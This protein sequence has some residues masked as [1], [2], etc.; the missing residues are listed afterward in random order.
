MSLTLA[1]LRERLRQLIQDPSG[2]IW[3]DA[4]LDEAVRLA[5][6]EYNLAKSPAVLSGLDG[7]ETTTLPEIYESALLLGAAGYAACSRALQRS[8]A[9]LPGQE[10]LNSLMDWGQ[11][12]LGEFRA[13]LGSSRAAEESR[14]TGLHG[15]VQPPF[16]AGTGQT[17]GGWRWEDEQ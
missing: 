4:G 8:A 17:S 3:T 6:H 5:L 16:P 1:S 12:R 2:L 10:G 11:A 13:M 7:A 9:A 15:A 14:L